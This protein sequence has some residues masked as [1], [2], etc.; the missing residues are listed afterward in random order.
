MVQRESKTVDLDGPVHY[1]DYGGPAGAQPPIVLVHGL[2]GSH[3]DWW[4]L[5]PMLAQ[6]RRV[7]AV[8]LPGFGRT[9]PSGLPGIR[10]YTQFVLNFVRAVAGGP[11]TLAGNSMGGGVAMHA[12][13][14]GPD[15]VE[16]LVLLNPIVPQPVF[17]LP[18]FAVWRDFAIC[19]APGVAEQLLARQP[20]R[21]SP[22]SI[23]EESL[24]MCCADP[25]RVEPA[26]KAALLDLA[27]ERAQMS[28][29]DRNLVEATRS[30]LFTILARSRFRRVIGDVRVPTLLI[31]GALDRLVT[32]RAAEATARAR[33]DWDTV[34]YE[35]VGHV[36][37][38]EA[39][40][41][42]AGTIDHWLADV[43]APA[44]V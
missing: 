11:V 15:V 39:P 34:V 44:S 22:L 3:V 14:D 9:P 2:G 10:N 38:I 19:L 5:G 43:R 29:G 35:D 25:F 20:H 31:H 12:A 27:T 4:S 26:H 40:R 6:G 8:D 28:Y 21:A 13:A 33:L 18:E 36:P 41:R 42:T 30:V 32:L 17:S 7:L 37:Q 16:R 24:S 1:V 23:V